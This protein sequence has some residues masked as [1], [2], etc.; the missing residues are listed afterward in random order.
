MILIFSSLQDPHAV[1]VMQRLDTRG[2]PYYLCDTE[3][4]PRELALSFECTAGSPDLFLTDSLSGETIHLQTVNVAWWRRPRPLTIHE[5]IQDPVA[6]QFAYN[7]C[8]MAIAG[9]WQ[10]I[11]ALWVNN[12]VFDEAAS[13]KV[14]QLKIAGEV[15]LKVPRTCITN[16]PATLERF[17]ASMHGKPVIYKS[18][19]AT[20]K[21]WRETR[22]L[23]AEAMSGLDS[24]KFA[25]VIFQ[26]FIPAV[27]DLRITVFGAHV[28]CIAVDNSSL[29]YA[30]D[31]RVSLESVAAS[32]FQLPDRVKNL[33]LR[34]MQR[35]RLVYGAIDMRLTPDGEFYFLE[36]NTAGEWQFLE[37]KTNLRITDRFSDFLAEACSRAHAHMMV[38]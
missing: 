16:D 1:A 3:R 33:I 20:E 21:A 15:G 22:L 23:S 12:P 25:P 37:E 26:E 31:Y 14:F 27:A 10:S 24:L 8:S 19:L 38:E 13:K 18:F 30:Y 5:E 17:T 28:F 36:V 29:H 11:D 35:L 9:L 2:V 34:F 7:E 4:F 32:E 6:V